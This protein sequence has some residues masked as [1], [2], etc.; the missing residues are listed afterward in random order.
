MNK[1]LKNTIIIFIFFKITIIIAS[2]L[3]EHLPLQLIHFEHLATEDIQF[4]DIYYSSRVIDIDQNKE[5][6]VI[7][8][9][10]IVNNE[11]FRSELGRLI[12]L[13][14]NY[15]PKKIGI[16]LLFEKQKEKDSILQ[17]SIFDNDVILAI[18]S[19][20]NHE[21]IF[22]SQKYGIINF[23][24]KEDETVREYYNYTIKNSIKYNS[25]VSVL[26]GINKED[27]IYYLK[28]NTDSKGYYDALNKS[29][30]IIVNNFPA[31]EASDILNKIDTLEV[32]KLIENKIVIIGHLGSGNMDNVYDI[33]DKFK[34]PNNS[35]LYNR[36]QT[37]PGAVIHA[38]ALQMVLNDDKIKKV[39][40]WLYEIITSIILYIFLLL[41][42]S[43]H[44]KYKLSK[45][46]NI[47]IILFS[48]IP[49][50]LLSCVYL[51]DMNVYFKVGTLFMQLVFLEEFIDISDGFKKLFIKN[52]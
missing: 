7:N 24:I 10:S 49:I 21:N 11:K 44:Q 12:N 13:I 51:M 8:S 36:V 9:G 6:I 18:D 20:N 27:S 46:I 15:K 50:I 30:K 33:E 41:F 47:L 19:K 28:Y 23:P 26:S 52:K 16:D 14:G 31:I 40:G 43:I 25:F 2:F 29:N 35:S 45:L 17:K 32:K 42:Y 37:M 1:L 48:T 22:K 3:Y 5:V 38:N 34:V 4:N 39:E